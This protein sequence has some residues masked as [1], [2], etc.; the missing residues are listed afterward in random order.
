MKYPKKLYFIG[1]FT[2]PPKMNVSNTTEA[3]AH[4]AQEILVISQSVRPFFC[5]DKSF[6]QLFF[7]II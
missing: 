3:I 1:P 2:N 7:I 6:F 5:N 4:N